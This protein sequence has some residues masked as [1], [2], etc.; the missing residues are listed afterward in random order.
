MRFAFF[1]VYTIELLLDNYERLDKVA[2]FI[3][4]KHKR[5]LNVLES[6]KSVSDELLGVNTSRHYKACELFHTESATGHKTAADLLV[7]HTAITSFAPEIKILFHYDSC[8]NDT[9]EL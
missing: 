2:G 4:H 7:T 8:F 5:G 1:S 6:Y 9:L 3:L